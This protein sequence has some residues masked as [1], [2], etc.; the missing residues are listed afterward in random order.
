MCFQRLQDNFSS[1]PQCSRSCE[2][3]S[4]YIQKGEQLSSKCNEIKQLGAVNIGGF[5][6]IDR[7]PESSL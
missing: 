4:K 6:T 3:E 1:A 2:S 7:M 5:E